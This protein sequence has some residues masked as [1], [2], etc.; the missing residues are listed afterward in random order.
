MAKVEM[1]L[2]KEELQQRM[3]ELDEKAQNQF[4]DKIYNDIEW[5]CEK[6]NRSDYV[7]TEYEMQV[8]SKIY[9]IVVNMDKWFS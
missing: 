4:I 2:T 1:G 7:A 3:R 6:A 5:L 8:F 9:N